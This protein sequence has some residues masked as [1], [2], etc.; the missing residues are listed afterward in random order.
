VQAFLGKAERSLA[1]KVASEQL[2]AVKSSF[3]QRLEECRSVL[4][5][6]MRDDRRARKSGAQRR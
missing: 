5:A 6:Q 3:D 4:M 2:T 1:T